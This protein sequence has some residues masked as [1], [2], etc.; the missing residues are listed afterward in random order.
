MTYHTVCHIEIEVTDLD[1]AQAFYEALFSWRFSPFTPDMVVF[2]VGDDHIGGLMRVDTVAPGR[3]PSVWY[4]VKDLDASIAL[5][6]AHGGTLS[7]PRSEVPGVGWSAVVSDPEGNRIGL[8]LF[9][10]D[11]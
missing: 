2:G 5:A 11:V 3:S 7:E 4:R 10:E 6:T 1:R 8:V 9:T